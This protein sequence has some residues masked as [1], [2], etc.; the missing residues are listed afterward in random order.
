[1]GEEGVVAI[2]GGGDRW[3]VPFE[4]LVEGGVCVRLGV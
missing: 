3:G 4:R 2:W 1:M